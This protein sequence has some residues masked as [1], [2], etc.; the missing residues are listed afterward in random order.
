ME[1]RIGEGAEGS[2]EGRP[3]HQRTE[4]PLSLWVVREQR[5]NV[6]NGGWKSCSGCFSLRSPLSSTDFSLGLQVH[7]MAKP[8]LSSVPSQ[9]AWKLRQPCSAFLALWPKLLSDLLLE[10]SPSDPKDTAH[11]SLCLNLLKFKYPKSS[12]APIHVVGLW[13]W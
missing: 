12:G 5:T 4:V 7:P 13:G 6:Q 2:T 8:K 3:T 10:G 11:F 1:W 9:P